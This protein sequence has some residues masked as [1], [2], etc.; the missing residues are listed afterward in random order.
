ML[1]ESFEKAY[2][3]MLPIMGGVGGSLAGWLQDH[4]LMDTVITA[5]VFSLVGGIVGY[6]IKVLMDFIFKNKKNGKHK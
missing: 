1:K 5:T 2:A 3:H 4:P 6:L